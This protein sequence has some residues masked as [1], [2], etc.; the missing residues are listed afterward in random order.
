MILLPNTTMTECILIAERIR[1]TIEMKAII[2]ADGETLPGVTV[3][4]GAAVNTVES[5]P[6]SLIDNADA[7]T[8]SR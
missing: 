6:T 8:L 5:T 3:S 2:T 4:I 7:K 1:Q